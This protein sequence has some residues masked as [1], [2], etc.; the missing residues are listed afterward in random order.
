MLNKDD[1]KKTPQ[2]ITNNSKKTK[3]IGVEYNENSLPQWNASI[4]IHG[5][6]YH[7]GSYL[8]EQHAAIAYDK[9]ALELFGLNAKRNFPKLSL[10]QIVERLNNIEAY[11]KFFLKNKGFENKQELFLKRKKSEYFGVYNYTT[12]KHSKKWTAI[13]QYKCKPNYIGYYNTEDDA[14]RAYD[15]KAIELF[16]KNAKRNFPDLTL[17]ELKEML[18]QSKSHYKQLCFEHRTKLRQGFI[19]SKNKTSKYVGVSKYKKNNKYLWTA[20]IKYQ[21]KNTFL[22][23]YQTEEEAAYAYDKKAFE[24]LGEKAKRNFPYLTIEELSKKVAEAK[25]NIT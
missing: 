16:G 11:N 20:F 22:G 18:N 6:Q 3:F 24:L 8:C 2:S 5:K 21:D 14:A 13:I 17:E 1:N 12:I 4:M 10:N 7:I 9:K 23:R 25:R 19:T 15:I